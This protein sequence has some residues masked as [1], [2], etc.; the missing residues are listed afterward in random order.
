MLLLRPSLY[1][2]FNFLFTGNIIIISNT[3]YKYY[4]SNTTNFIPSVDNQ[5]ER[6]AHLESDN[7]EIKNK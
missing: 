7:I 4:V 2:Y 3:T 5:E 6:V 1:I